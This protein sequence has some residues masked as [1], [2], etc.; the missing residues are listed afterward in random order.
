[1]STAVS[2]TT[3]LADE[4]R[5]WDERPSG[6][7]RVSAGAVLVALAYAAL[8]YAA[9]VG[10]ASLPTHEVRTGLGISPFVLVFFLLFQVYLV[11]LG[12][13]LVYHRSLVHRA[14]KLHPL[15][16]YPLLVVALPAGTPVQWV[17]NHRHHHAFTD[18]SAD[19]HSPRHH[20]LWAAHAGW[21]IYSRNPLLCALYSLGGPLRMLF[22]AFWRPQTNQEHVALARDVAR[23]PFFG[24]VSKP[25]PYAFFVIGHVVG[26]WLLVYLLWGVQGLVPLYLLQL[27]YFLIGDSVNSVLHTWGEQPFASRDESRNSALVAAFSAGEGFHNGHHAFPRSVQCGL[28]PGQID[29]AYLQARAFERVG[30][31][32]DLVVPSAREILEKLTDE[33]HRAHFEAKLAKENVS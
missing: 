13:G 4:T 20:G 15:V 33:R 23:E 7:V 16:A 8:A 22:D 19:H 28:L 3:V 21:Y 32:T 31:A 1:M 18:T 25:V 12:V 6:F 26:T 2:G 30:L 27:S 24:W 17:G 9:L 10:I 11:G 29:L 5:S 14:C